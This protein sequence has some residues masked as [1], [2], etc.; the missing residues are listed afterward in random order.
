MKKAQRI[1]LR[2]FLWRRIGIAPV[3]CFQLLHHFAAQRQLIAVDIA[4]QLLQRRR[5]Q[6]RAGD[7]R[8][9]THKGQRHL[10]RIEP[11]LA[12][13]IDI[14]GNRLLRLLAAV[15]R[16]AA[17][18]RIAGTRRTRAIQVFAA[19]RSERKAGVSQQLD[20]FMLADFRQTH[21]KAAVQQAVGILNR[22]N[23]RQFMLFRQLQITHDAPGRF[24]GDADI[25]HLSGAT[26]SASASSVSSSVTGTLVSVY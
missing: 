7:E 24:V 4:L 26:C 12:C 9:L 5:A 11:V 17:E 8:L 21:F 14:F 22:D 19:Q 18:Q 13:Q 10:R 20:A 23:A 16:K 2:F 1:T 25:A 3:N 6:Q 15:A